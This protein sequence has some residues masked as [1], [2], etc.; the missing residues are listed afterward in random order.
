M[1]TIAPLDVSILTRMMGTSDPA[2]L[3]DVT[4]L[5]VKSTRRML[6]D[7]RRAWERADMDALLLA[8]HGLKGAA[9]TVGA[10]PLAGIMAT[11][12]DGLRR[13]TPNLPI[14]ESLAQS[15]DEFNRLV[16]WLRKL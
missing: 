5:F 10:T 9:R 1:A 16:I 15:Q 6:G 14:A 8:A 3:R 2:Y 13:K 11:L 7:L 4:R 12:E